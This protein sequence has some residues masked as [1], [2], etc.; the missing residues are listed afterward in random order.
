MNDTTCTRSKGTGQAGVTAVELVV[1]LVLV[2]LLAL[3]VYPSL[4]NILQVMTSKG[5][6]EQ[7]GSAMRQARQ[8]A[9]TSGQ[10][11]CIRFATV[12]SHQ[13]TIGPTADTTAANCTFVS[14][15]DFPT[16]T[17]PIGD[18]AGSALVSPSNQSLIF[19]PIG[20]VLNQGTSTPYVQQFVVDTQPAACASTIG[21]T[22][23][24][25]VRVMKC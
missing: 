4:S 2:A 12:P 15:P 21:V 16:R 10:N 9:I 25:G 8:Y 17:E 5:A 3:A 23:Y 7:V 20:N 19:N 11:Y 13:Y 14:D 6:A 18:G 24:G 22:L 1:V